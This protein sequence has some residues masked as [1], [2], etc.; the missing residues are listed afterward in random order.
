MDSRTCVL[1]EKHLVVSWPENRELDKHHNSCEVLTGQ[2][3]HKLLQH[4][5]PLFPRDLRSGPDVP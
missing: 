5:Q 4:P 3:H 1:Q 2:G